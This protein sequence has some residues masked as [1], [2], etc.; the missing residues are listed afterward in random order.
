MKPR[1][2]ISWSGGKDCCLALLREWDAVEFTAAITMFGE[3]GER[4]RSHGLRPAVVS[5]Q[6]ERL[7]LE[8][9][10]G[11]CTWDTYTDRYV[12][13]L[14]QVS[15][16]G[17]THVV[18]GD[19]IG[20]PHREWNAR[21]CAHHGLT[22]V[23][24]L[25]GESTALLAREF[26]ARGGEAT[27]VTVRPPVLD[28]SWLGVTLDEDALVRLEALGVD[29]C[30]ELG[31]YHTVVTNCPRFSTPLPLAQGERVM[32]GGCWAIDLTMS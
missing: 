26:I 22:P 16:R 18:F 4:S 12:A 3:D 17:I 15:A 31:E 23:M 5:A 1:A 25:W 28:E 27:M 13:L 24:P 20:D 2:A 32:R 10:S 6:V 30:G 11:R 9:L 8:Q 29:P 14:A 21:V 7:G 19:I